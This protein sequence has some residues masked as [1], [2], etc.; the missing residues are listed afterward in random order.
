MLLPYQTPEQAAE[1]DRQARKRLHENKMI[2][3]NAI[4]EACLNP[5]PNPGVETLLKGASPAQI[6]GVRSHLLERQAYWS[7][8]TA[9]IEAANVRRAIEALDEGRYDY[10]HIA[11]NLDDAVVQKLFR[12]E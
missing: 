9:R 6:L 12:K 10:G 11:S 5:K 4:S 1:Q 2:L 8:M 7:S 3:L